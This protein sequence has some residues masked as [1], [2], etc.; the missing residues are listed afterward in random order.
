MPFARPGKRVAGRRD[1]KVE[2][3]SSRRR[4]ISGRVLKRGCGAERS[5]KPSTGGKTDRCRGIEHQSLTHPIWITK[6]RR[7]GSPWVACRTQRVRPFISSSE[8]LFC[9][10]LSPSLAAFLPRSL[11]LSLISLSGSFSPR[12]NIYPAARRPPTRGKTNG[13]VTAA[14]LRFKTDLIVGFPAMRKRA[15]YIEP[16]G[17]YT[18]IDR[19]GAA[20]RDGKK[21]RCVDQYSTKFMFLLNPL[22]IAL[23]ISPS[24]RRGPSLPL[25]PCFSP[26]SSATASSPLS[27]SGI[28][29]TAASSAR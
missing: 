9:G 29:V 4:M 22:G 20:R 21:K 17:P 12:Q 25:V 28:K 18:C 5:K 7:I 11:F 15:R 24:I 27:L 8:Q 23:F 1:K 16:A 13:L 26:L 3:T 10:S 6:V 2:T 19:R 14:T